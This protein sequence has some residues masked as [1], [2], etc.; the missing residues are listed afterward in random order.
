MCT[1]KSTFSCEGSPTAWDS[2]SNWISPTEA[3]YF[4]NGRELYL[5]IVIDMNVWFIDSVDSV[6]VAFSIFS[7]I[8]MDVIKTSEDADNYD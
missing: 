6:I 4:F 2:S 7:I 3:G 8:S 5:V 1:D